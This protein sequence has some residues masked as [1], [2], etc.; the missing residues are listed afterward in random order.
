[1][2]SK[3]TSDPQYSHGYL[4]PVFALILLWMRR[5]QLLSA[6]LQPSWWGLPLVAVGAALHVLAAYLYYEGLDSSSLFPC[7]FGLCLVTAGWPAVRWAW[8]AIGFLVFMLP[9]PFRIEVALALPLQRLAT[10]SST[11]LLQTLGFPAVAEGN[12]I[13]LNE[14][15]LNV[16]EACSGL[17]MVMTFFALSTAVAFVV[18]RR[19][20]DKILIG[21]S[22]LPIAVLANLLRITVTGIL[23][24]TVGEKVANLVFHDLAGWLMMP[25][26]LGILWL[27]LQILSRLMIEPE[28]E[29][30][31]KL[32][33]SSL[34]LA[35]AP[36]RPRGA[37]M[38]S[39]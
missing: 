14:V 29:Q 31:P 28:P 17:S 38:F 32:D 11:Y 13:L 19:W 23:H 15:R 2:A 37:T 10:R 35:P 7:L 18:K 21:L 22:A 26:A 6:T 30:R 8:P 20:P 5:Q 9:L 33:L 36:S 3:W 12:T 16:V 25:L 4:V 34:A 24:E 27:E 1:M 39:R